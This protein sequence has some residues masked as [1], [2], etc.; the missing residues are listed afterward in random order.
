MFS[1]DTRA[2]THTHTVCRYW[3][4]T[5]SATSWTYDSKSSTPGPSSLAFHSPESLAFHSPQ[6]LR[7]HS[8]A[9]AAQS[10]KAILG[11]RT[12]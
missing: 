7:F 10:K 12:T 11:C 9:C 8:P 2:R 5:R 1:I 3:R 4:Q 6:S